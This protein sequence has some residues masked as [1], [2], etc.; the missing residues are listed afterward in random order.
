MVLC[1]FPQCLCVL[2]VLFDYHTMLISYINDFVAKEE[3]IPF[4]YK[5]ALKEVLLCAPSIIV[6]ISSILLAISFG[7][8]VGDQGFVASHLIFECAYLIALLSLECYLHLSRKYL[9]VCE[10]LLC[11]VT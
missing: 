8:R 3:A 4:D 2:F 11:K 5:A 9:Q 10:V 1:F 7:L 6:I